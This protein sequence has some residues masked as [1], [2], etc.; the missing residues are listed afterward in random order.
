MN[1][2]LSMFNKHLKTCSNIDEISGYKWINEDELNNP[3][4]I[5]KIIQNYIKKRNNDNKSN[6]PQ[7]IDKLIVLEDYETISIYE[8]LIETL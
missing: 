5:N 2:L 7:N 4:E 8:G 3:S 1:D 6:F